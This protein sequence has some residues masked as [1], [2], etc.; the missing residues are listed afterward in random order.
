MILTAA[1][2]MLIP[3][4]GTSLGAL[5]VLVFRKQ[6]HTCCFPVLNGFASGIMV[7]ASIWSLILPALE[8]P[9][10][11]VFFPLL[12]AIAGLWFGF[13]LLYFLDQLTARLHDSS[14]STEQPL[15]GGILTSLAITLHNLPEGMSV[16][17]VTAGWLSGINGIDHSALLAL[18]LGIAIQNIPEGAIV[19]L[20]LWVGGMRK[21]RAAWYGILSG[22][23][24]PLGA[25][26][27]VLFI[28]FLAPALPFL[29]CFSAGA[30]LYVVVGELLPQNGAAAHSTKCTMCFCGGFTL[31][32]ALDVLL[33]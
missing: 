26:S 27:T 9:S 22:I 16:G 17:V 13:A 1:T 21:S 12:S 19:S 24:E 10:S 7:A 15:P 30:M 3:F 29:L 2:A 20:Q 25:I 5:L 6:T 33:K 31:M 28:T 23:V 14:R 4:L 32:M 8:Q 11:H 18:T